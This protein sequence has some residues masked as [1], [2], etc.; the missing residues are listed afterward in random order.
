MKTNENMLLLLEAME[1]ASYRL[2]FE[3]TKN[4]EP[5]LN[6]VIQVCSLLTTIGEVKDVDILRASVLYELLSK[7]NV[8]PVEIHLRFGPRTYAIVRKLNLEKSFIHNKE[9][10]FQESYSGLSKA[11]NMIQMADIIANVEMMVSCPPAG[12]DIERR[13]IFLQWAAKSINE[14]KGACPLLEEYYHCIYSPEGAEED[15]ENKFKKISA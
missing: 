2:K 1:F 13:K 5:Y 3:K 9:I 7:T 10:V 12:W 8:K 11:A 14:L 4:D 6:H 15:K